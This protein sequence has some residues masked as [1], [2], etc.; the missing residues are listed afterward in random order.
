MPMTE[1]I[2]AKL[3]AG[4]KAMV[5]L[6]LKISGS[7]MLVGVLSGFI[8]QSLV[9]ADGLGQNDWWSGLACVGTVCSLLMVAVAPLPCDK[10]LTKAVLF[11]CFAFGLYDILWSSLA[12]RHR[13]QA[14]EE[15]IPCMRQ[16]QL[17]A[18]EYCWAMVFADAS[19]IVWDALFCVTA[20]FIHVRRT[21][22]LPPVTVQH[23][24]WRMIAGWLALAAISDALYVMYCLHFLSILDGALLFLAFDLIGV[25]FALRRSAHQAVQH[26]IRRLF[27][28]HSSIAAAA[29]IASLMGTVSVQEALAQGKERF[30]GVSL[31][32]VEKN[33]FSQEVGK[34]L[35][36][37]SSAS[38]RLGLGQVDAFISHSWHD[39]ADVKWRALQAWRSDF[40]VEHGREPIVWFDK[41]CVNQSD[42][43]SDLR[44]LPIFV[45][46]C[47]NF[48]VLC[49]PSYL[50][51]L[52]C[53]MELFTFFHMGGKMEQLQFIPL[54]R[55]GYEADD[56]EA[57]MSTF[58]KFD[59]RSCEC[60]FAD[61]KQNILAIIDAA[62]GDMQDFN[63]A[64]R[65]IVDNSAFKTY[66]DWVRSANLGGYCESEDCTSI[67]S[68]SDLH[69][70]DTTHRTTPPRTPTV[71]ASPSSY[72]AMTS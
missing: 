20:V 46:G 66:A 12:V 9:I 54:Q 24:L 4:Q 22:H 60:A 61:D 71:W 28:A 30:K 10:P 6:R 29:G 15:G 8:S 70:G 21:K 27:E 62:F 37:S 43:E 68:D 18:D 56:Q 2:R 26:R 63:K 17:V 48:V 72:A 40:I 49:G 36:E 57:I 58:D 50:T 23:L 47:K 33:W 32:K 11:A 14:F 51:R 65:T 16:G 35:S 1:E 31:D 45:R 41:A 59:V 42:I 55:F 25:A 69:C 64:V 44:F 67:F 53:V 39:D 7:I 5:Q 19:Y 13:L 3:L 38:A 52:W 34:T